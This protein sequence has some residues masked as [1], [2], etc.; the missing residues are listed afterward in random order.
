[1]NNISKIFIFLCLFLFLIPQVAQAHI[2]GVSAFKI[3][4]VNTKVY[5][6]QKGESSDLPPDSDKAPEVYRVG[7]EL[8]LEFETA[9][10]ITPQV[11][12]DKTL[13]IWDFGDGD[14]QS[15]IKGFKMTHAYQQ[16]RNTF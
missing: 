1:M 6:P 3:N 2:K 7:Q 12:W 13:L 15:I 9:K 14:K 16:P 10:T 8:L 4:D 11:I 5:K